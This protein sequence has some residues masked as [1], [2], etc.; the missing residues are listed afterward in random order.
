M[1]LKKLA[2][3]AAVATLIPLTAACSSGGGAYCDAIQE[4]NSSG[5]S[6]SNIGDKDAIAKLLPSLKK[7]EAAAPADIK[8]EWTKFVS[9]MEKFNQGG[10]PSA[11]AQ[12]AQDMTQAL[13]KI[14]KSV[15]DTC[16]I[17]L[18]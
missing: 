9:F 2:A 4:A 3:T 7:I 17:T 10:D 8:G 13:P 12:E 5:V 1:N 18:T 6:A 14:Q 11:L 15:K 16:N